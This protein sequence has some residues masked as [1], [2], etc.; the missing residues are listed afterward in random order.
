MIHVPSLKLH[1][2]CLSCCDYKVADD[3]RLLLISAVIVST[4]SSFEWNSSPFLQMA[5][6]AYQEKGAVA[7]LPMILN[8]FWGISLFL[9]TA[10][11]I[12]FGSLFSFIHLFCE[13]IMLF[14]LFIIATL[15][16]N[17]STPTRIYYTHTDTCFLSTLWCINFLIIVVNVATAKDWYL[18]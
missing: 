9:P 18:R 17:T 4:C 15:A 13:P 8:I 2:H 3:L 1:V 14:F 6:S 10:A 16:C 11:F 7:L 12:L 5:C